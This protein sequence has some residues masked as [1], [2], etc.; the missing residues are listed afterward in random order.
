MWVYLVSGFDPSPRQSSWEYFS[1]LF[2]HS[3]YHSP[4]HF[5]SSKFFTVMLFSHQSRHV[6]PLGPL[7]GIHILQTS[8]CLSVPHVIYLFPNYAFPWS[9]RHEMQ[10]YSPPSTYTVS[11]SLHLCF[12]CSSYEPIKYILGIILCL[13]TVSHHWSQEFSLNL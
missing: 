11:I 10:W 9:P 4:P 3:S 1:Y 8:V 2:G 12:F 13:F 6:P 7:P 5:V